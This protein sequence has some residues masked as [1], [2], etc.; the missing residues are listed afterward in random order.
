LHI[1]L[2]SILSEAVV[3]E[4]NAV[5]EWG[6]LVRHGPKRVSGNAGLAG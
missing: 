4:P 5:Q 3:P 1:A 2:Q 6:V